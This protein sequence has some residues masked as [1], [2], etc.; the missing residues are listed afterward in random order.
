LTPPNSPQRGE[1]FSCHSCESRNPDDYLCRNIFG[2][3]QKNPER[4]KQKGINHRGHR[5]HGGWGAMCGELYSVMLN[6]CLN[7][8]SFAS[9]VSQAVTAGRWFSIFFP[10]V[11]FLSMATDPETSSG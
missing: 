8:H 1:F 7:C 6:S 2:N 4:M 10:D 11:Q 3:T 5:A 9:S